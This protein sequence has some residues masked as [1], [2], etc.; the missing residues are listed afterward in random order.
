MC[1]VYVW[2][3]VLLRNIRAARLGV[4][5]PASQGVARESERDPSSEGK[6]EVTGKRRKIARR[7]G[8]GGTEPGNKVLSG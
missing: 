6:M 8:G 4:L 3:D 1:V 7:R 2:A 5:L